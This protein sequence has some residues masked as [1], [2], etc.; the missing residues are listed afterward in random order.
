MVPADLANGSLRAVEHNRAD[1]AERRRAGPA[2][3]EAEGS[4]RAE[5]GR[6]APLTVE[7]RRLGALSL[8]KRAVHC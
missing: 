8:S 4:K 1:L 6:G 2:L 5:L 7:G 3:S